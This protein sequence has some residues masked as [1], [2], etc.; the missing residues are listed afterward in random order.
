MKQMF[1][2]LLFIL[3]LLAGC[4]Q[5]A[6]TTEDDITAQ[7]ARTWITAVLQ[8]DGA[9]IAK[10]S[11]GSFDYVKPSDTVLTLWYMGL[12]AKNVDVDPNTLEID[13]EY[14][15]T[16]STNST[17][18]VHVTGTVVILPTLRDNQMDLPIPLNNEFTVDD[19]WKMSLE[20]E[21]WKWCGTIAPIE[22]GG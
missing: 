4:Q 2:I 22:S 7:A 11:C 10:L 18:E 8:Q 16:K 20:S 3:A 17:A 19:T 6:D 14:R 5:E 15:T 21:T 12:A 1:F 9:A 13:L